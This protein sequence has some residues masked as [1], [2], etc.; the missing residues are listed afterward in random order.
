MLRSSLDF[1]I[2]KT[3]DCMHKILSLVAWNI[4]NKK[5]LSSKAL[6]P[7]ILSNSV[8][9]MSSYS[10]SKFGNKLSFVWGFNFSVFPIEDESA[11]LNSECK[12]FEIG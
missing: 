2:K 5:I 10:Q 8:E 7:K 1:A 11:F 3:I 6:D 12:L 9:P 4:F